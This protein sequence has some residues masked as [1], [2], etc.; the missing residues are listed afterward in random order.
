LLVVSFEI[1]I[2]FG[3]TIFILNIKKIMNINWKRYI[4]LPIVPP[5]YL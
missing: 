5:E 1:H 4:L 3:I 2:Q